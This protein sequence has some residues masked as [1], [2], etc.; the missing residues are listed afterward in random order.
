MG[1]RFHTSSWSTSLAA[2][3]RSDRSIPETM[4]LRIGADVARDSPT[5]TSG[6]LSTVT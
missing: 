6:A 4:L 2:T 3:S 5:P 1:V